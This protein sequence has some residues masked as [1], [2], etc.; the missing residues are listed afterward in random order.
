MI[1]EMLLGVIGAGSFVNGIVYWT[2]FECS[3]SCILFRVQRLADNIYVATVLVRMATFCC[4]ERGH[5]DVVKLL[6]DRGAVEYIDMPSPVVRP[7]TTTYLFHS[8]ISDNVCGSYR[9]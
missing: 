4:Y 3:L 2:S 8:H 7:F 1:R 6:L 5:Y 9:I